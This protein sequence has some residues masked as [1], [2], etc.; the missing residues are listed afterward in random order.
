MEQIE[1]ML[2]LLPLALI[3]LNIAGLF[4]SKPEP[5]TTDKFLKH[6]WDLA[7][8][9]HSLN[10][11]SKSALLDV[12]GSLRAN[13]RAPEYYNVTL[14]NATTLLK[15]EKRLRIVGDGPSAAEIFLE[16]PLSVKNDEGEHFPEVE[17]LVRLQL[18]ELP[19]SQIHTAFFRLPGFE[20]K[21]LV[22]FTELNGNSFVITITPEKTTPKLVSKTEDET[23]KIISPTIIDEP[24]LESGDDSSESISQKAKKIR[25]E[26]I[27]VNHHLHI[28]ELI[29]YVSIHGVKKDPT[30]EASQNKEQQTVDSQINEKDKDED[31]SDDEYLI[32]IVGT[33]QAEAKKPS[34]M[35]QILPM[36]LMFLPQLLKKKIQPQV[37]GQ[38]Q[39]GQPGQPGHEH[40]H[41]NARP[42][43]Q[44][45]TVE[46][47]QDDDDKNKNKDDEEEEE[48]EED[49]DEGE[50]DDE[51]EEDKKDA[52]VNKID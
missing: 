51:E 49:D 35:T 34:M 15:I 14:R 33:Q 48:E 11:E 32:V 12:V 25:K 30:K 50:D 20:D 18:N 27:E 19:G 36:L 24:K 17:K 22:H 16:N 4:G 44:T 42:R 7:I 29:N 23:L 31:V 37:P 39:Q 52:D 21:F 13:F 46:E 41:P 38:A 6:N 10:G 8:S 28:K 47:I 1:Q 5:F 3:A 43:R 9:R 45:A 40:V 26:N 2:S